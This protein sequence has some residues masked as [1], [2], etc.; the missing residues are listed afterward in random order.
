MKFC[1]SCGGELVNEIPENDNLPRDVCR[2]C[3]AVHYINPTMVVGTL[4]RWQNQILLCLRD[5][6]PARGRWTLPA[7]FLEMTET[8]A[9]GAARETYEETGV[10]PTGLRPYRMYDI[11]H[12][13]QIYL[14]FLAELP[15][16]SFHPTDESREV[17][18]FTA[19][20]IP[21][22]EIAFPVIEQTLR[23]YVDDLQENDF[24]FQL[25]QITQ[26]MRK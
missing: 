6:E 9:A 5:I 16:L 11:V 20:E 14:L 21:W 2:R 15:E 13:G 3:G 10:M 4:P 24:A 23:D 26:R 25:G 17:R 19:S 18:L 12:I 1:P 8:M 22:K 7:G